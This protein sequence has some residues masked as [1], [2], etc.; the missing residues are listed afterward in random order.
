MTDYRRKGKNIVWKE[1]YNNDN[2]VEDVFNHVD[3]IIVPS[4]WVENSPLVIHEA[5]EAGV[6]VITAD[7]GG[8]KEHIQHGKNGLLF[9]HRNVLSLKEQMQLLIDHPKKIEA[10]STG[11]YLYSEDKH[12]PNIMTHIEDL[13]KIYLELLK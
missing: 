5:L 9:K 10:L 12:I 3:C 2:I 7:I 13:E 4:I 1:E 11:G 6:C 8:M